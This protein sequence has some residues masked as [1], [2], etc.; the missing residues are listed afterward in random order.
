MKRG[1]LVTAILLLVCVIASAITY[2]AMTSSPAFVYTP[3]HRDVDPEEIM[4]VGLPDEVRATLEQLISE[5]DPFS[6]TGGEKSLLVELNEQTGLDRISLITYILLYE[7]SLTNES[8]S[9]I[10]HMYRMRVS[11]SWDPDERIIAALP[12][13]GSDDSIIR[14]VGWE[15]LART[16]VQSG[17]RDFTPFEQVFAKLK[18]EEAHR[19]AWFMYNEDPHPAI[20][21]IANA[22][23]TRWLR[24]KLLL[25]S[26]P[27]FSDD[28]Q[29]VPKDKPVV[30]AT[31]VKSDLETYVDDDRWWVRMYAARILSEYWGLRKKEWVDKLLDDPNV[32]IRRYLKD[33]HPGQLYGK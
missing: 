16:S 1:L 30:E 4:E 32:Y 26:I 15:I 12:L 33:V 5:L 21:S 18:E 31:D 3:I 19:L 29:D 20:E 25:A 23:E 14:R 22:L 7:G 6:G 24:R 10:A 11:P 17:V 13:F 8:E 2:R 28:L 27:M 9:L